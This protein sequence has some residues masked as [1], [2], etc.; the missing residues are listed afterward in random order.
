MLSHVNSKK[1][2]MHGAVTC[3]MLGDCGIKYAL[4]PLLEDMVRAHLTG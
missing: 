4:A 1:K 3:R 2:K